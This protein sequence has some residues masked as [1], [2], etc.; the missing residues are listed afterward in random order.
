MAG[1]GAPLLSCAG[2]RAEAALADIDL[3][4]ASKEWG[5]AGFT[6]PL[7]S[8]LFVAAV[9]DPFLFG[10]DKAS[11]SLPRPVRIADVAARDEV[12][13]RIVVMVPVEVVGDQRATSDSFTG[14]PLDLASAPMAGVRPRT[15]LVV[16]DE[17]VNGHH[18]RRRCNRVVG[19]TAHRWINDRLPVSAPCSTTPVVARKRAKAPRSLVPPR[20]EITTAVLTG[21]GFHGRNSTITKGV[22]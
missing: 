20:G 4:D 8:S 15:D 10:A 9:K 6:L 14:L 19:N 3:R 18:P 16:K 1:L 12:F 13:G 2:A 7:D 22:L 17:A 21:P 11:V 5:V